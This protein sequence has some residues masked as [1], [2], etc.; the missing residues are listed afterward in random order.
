MSIDPF[1]VQVRGPL[2]PFAAGFAGELAQRGYTPISARGQMRL[3][4]R[5][6]CWLALEGM[7]AEDLSVSEVD[8][9]V[10]TRRAAGRQ[11]RSIKALR[12]ILAYLKSRG[13][14]LPST[15][16]PDDP[17]EVLLERYRRYL[18]AERGLA[19]ATADVYA[20]KVRPFVRHRLSSDG[21]VLDLAGLAATDIVAFVVMHC[22]RLSRSAASLTV[23]A[24]RSL[25]GYLNIEGLIARS[26]AACVPSVARSAIGWVPERTGLRPGSAPAD[27]LRPRYVERLPRRRGHDHVGSSRLAGGGS[28][29]AQA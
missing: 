20:Q 2:A 13:V 10:R 21:R 14:V 18:T 11:L 22:P 16:A 3:L 9:F 7:D 25:L 23:T 5:L 4:A 15:R 8:R 12:P 28:R 17:A 29:Q 24:L 26:L 6:S 19:N 1:R 27:V